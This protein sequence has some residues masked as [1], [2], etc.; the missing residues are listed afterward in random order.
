MKAQNT[1]KT[2]GMK[3][4]ALI[5]G[6]RKWVGGLWNG[7]RWREVESRVVAA[8]R[9]KFLA[10]FF[11]FFLLANVAQ[12]S[13]VA[14]Q[15]FSKLNFAPIEEP[16]TSAPLQSIG[17]IAVLVED[18]LMNDSLSY[19]GLK[20]HQLDS[21]KVISV[22]FPNA[23]TANSLAER[24]QRYALD[25]QR[26]RSLQKSHIIK[27]PRDAD[28]AEIANTLENIYLQGEAALLNQA[29]G[30]D[31][32][33]AVGQGQ[34]AGQ[35]SKLVGVVVIGD[36][37]LPVINKGGYRFVSMYPYTDFS[38][39]LYI[40]DPGKK[41]FVR[42]SD[43]ETG[44]V[45]VWHGV[46]KPPVSGDTGN[47]LLA[48]YFDKNHL[49]H[50]KSIDCFEPAQEFKN[51]SKKVLFADLFHEWESMNKDGY[52]NYVRYLQNMEDFAYSRF[53]KYLAGKLNGQFEDSLKE[54][55]GIDNDGDGLIDE[56]PING[57]DD[58]GDG[59]D[60]SPLIGM[61]NGID[62]N[63]NGEVD[64]L[65][66]G[67]WGICPDANNDDIV[68]PITVS[69]KLRDCRTADWANQQAVRGSNYFSVK[70]GSLYKIS[71]EIDNDGNG[72]IDE[73]IDEDNGDALKG[74]DNDFDGLIDEDTTQDND[75]DGDGA[76][77]EDGPGDMNDDNCPGV[78]GQDEDGDSRD[79]DGD[80]YPNGYEIEKGSFINGLYI[81]TNPK[82]YTSFPL[83]MA[84]V[85]PL[86]MI[87]KPSGNPW[88]DEGSPA[89]DDEDGLV[90]EDG[91][92]DND[93]DGDGMVDEDSDGGGTT[94]SL[95]SLPDAFSRDLIEKFAA[96]YDSLFDKFKA[97]INDWIGYTGRY[98]SSYT[99][100][101]VAKSDV[102]TIPGLITIKDKVTEKYLRLAAD[103][104]EQ[105]ID[106]LV[107]QKLVAPVAMLQG[108]K[109]QLRV[110]F[111]DPNT[112]HVF[113]PILE[114][115]N[116]ANH[117]YSY[118]DPLNIPHTI[119]FLY[120]N[121]K[122]ATEIKST[123]ECS[124]YRGSQG[125]PG[126]NSALVIAS[127]LYNGLAD[128]TE[129]KAYAGCIGKN[130][131]LPE[132][133]FI[134]AA[135]KPV[136]DILGTKLIDAMTPVSESELDYRACFD[137]K[138][139]KAYE[140]YTQSVSTF[141]SAASQYGGSAEAINEAVASGQL[142]LPGSPYVTADNLVLVDSDIFPLNKVNP[143]VPLVDPSEQHFRLTLTLADFLK[144]FGGSDGVDNNGDGVI[145][146]VAE[147]GSSFA[148]GN[149]DF[150]QIG[151]KILQGK[152]ITNDFVPDSRNF[153]FNKTTIPTLPAEVGDVYILVE[154][155]PAKAV[156]SGGGD[157]LV[158]SFDMHKEPTQETIDAQTAPGV[159]A[160]SLPIDNPR[161]VT[162]QDKAGNFQRLDY[163]KLFAYNSE[164][165]LA[166]IL[167]NFEKKLQQIADD[168]N[169][170]ADFAGT[171]TS[172]LG[173]EDVYSDPVAKERLYKIDRNKLDD[174]YVWKG[175][176][177]DDKHDYVISKYLN[178]Y[179]E[180][181]FGGETE[182]GYEFMY[183]VAEG[184]S[185]QML[186]GFNA[187]FNLVDE[188]SERKAIDSQLD[189]PTTEP[190]GGSGGG[191]G[192]GSDDGVN[193]LKWFDAIVDWLAE[194]T[195]VKDSTQAG[196]VCLFADALGDIAE[197]AADSETPAGSS[198]VMLDFSEG[199]TEAKNTAQ[200]SVASDKNVMQAGSSDIATITVTGLNDQGQVQ[201]KDS[202]TKVQL[203][204]DP[205]QDAPAELYS[206]NPSVLINGKATFK[207]ITT[208]VVGNFSVYAIDPDRPQV[209]SNSVSISATNKKIRLVTYRKVA[210]SEYQQGDLIGFIIKDYD[211]KIITFVNAE[212]G[213]IDLKDDRFELQALPSGAGKPVRLT[214]AFKNGGEIVASVYF[215]VDAAKA[216]TVDDAAVNYFSGDYSG[217]HVK[218]TDT[219]DNY[220]IKSVAYDSVYNANGAY[221]YSDDDKVGIVDTS[222]NLFLTKDYSLGLNA[223]VGTEGPVVFDVLDS[224]KKIIAELFVAADFPKIEIIREEGDFADFNL[225]YHVARNAFAVAFSMI[226]DRASLSA[227]AATESIG[228]NGL[229]DS[230]SD[231][232][233]DF[234]EII[235]GL[236]YHKADS[237]GDGFNDYDELLDN[238]DPLKAGAVLFS[239]L[240]NVS[241]GFSQIINLF[242]RGV[243]RR[244]DDGTFRP[245]QLL[246]RDEF[247]ELNFGAICVQCTNFSDNVKTAIDTEYSKDPFPD[248]NIR[249][250]LLYCVKDAKN[251]TIVSG[252]QG[253]STFGFFLPDQSIS[254]AEAVKV[255]L[256]T[257]QLEFG[258]ITVNDATTPG[259]PWYYNYVVEGQKQALFPAGTFVELDGDS[260]AFVSWFDTQFASNGIFIKWLEGS[261]TRREF[262]MMVSNFSD[263]YNC[264]LK[265]SDGD[266]IPDNFEIYVYGTS[267]TSD[268]TD[269]GGVKDM[270]ELL[271]NTNP[272]DPKDDKRVL[273]PD[274]DDDNDGMPNG[275]EMTYGF[276]PY[277]P[278]DANDDPDGD[279]LKNLK[280][281]QI[282]TD[283]LDPDTDDGG[284][285]DGDEV[286]REID[287]LN[288]NDD[289]FFGGAEGGFI[290]GDTV[291]ENYSYAL[292]TPEPGQ[293]AFD[294]EYINEMP[295]DGQSS[296]YLRA[297]VVDENGDA[298]ETVDGSLAFGAVE[299]DGFATV[300]FDSM[301]ITE[302]VAENV[303]TSKLKAGD[304]LAT[305]SFGDEYPSEVFDVHVIPLE[306]ANIEL[307]VDSKVIKSGGESFA[308]V[309]AEL[310]D[311]NLNLINNDIQQLTFKISGGRAD[312]TLDE[313]P[314]MDGV[315]ISSLDGKFDLK[316]YSVEQSGN[317][318]VT[319]EYYSEPDILDEIESEIAEE[320]AVAGDET[321]DPQ[322]TAVKP[323]ITESVSVVTRDDLNLRLSAQYSALPSDFTSTS[324]LKLSVTDFV[325]NVIEDF[326]GVARFSVSNGDLGSVSVMEAPIINGGGVA[327]FTSGRI[328]GEASV[329]AA[330]E[331]FDSAK[332]VIAIEPKETK[333]IQVESNRDYIDANGGI[334]TTI[335]AKLFDADGNFAGND[336]TTILRF[337]LSE[338]SKKFAQI[339]GGP[340]GYIDIQAQNGI[341]QMDVTGISLS[342]N[343][344]IKVSAPG[345]N[346][347]YTE[348]KV[349][350]SFDG[351]NFRGINPRVLYSSLLGADFGNIFHED[352]LAGWLIFS[353]KTQ[354]ATS[355]ISP[356]TPK[357]RLVEVSPYGK[358][359][360]MDEE[361]IGFKYVDNRV[362]VTDFQTR[363]DLGEVVVVMN[364][365]STAVVIES[366]A[367]PSNFVGSVVVQLNETASETGG[368]STLDTA[369]GVN[370]LEND[371]LIA[372]VM[373]SGNIKVFG[374]GYS[375]SP[376]IDS[377]LDYSVMDVMS[378]NQSVASVILVP[379]SPGNVVLL[380][381][382]SPEVTSA[383]YSPGIYLRK[384]NDISTIGSDITF[385]GY[386]SAGAKGI[387]LTDLE[388]D[389]P[390]SQIPGQSFASLEKATEVS[391][392]GFEGD[393][394]HALLFAA[395]NTV[396]ESN[397]PYASEIGIVIGDP[398]IRM[399]NSA[400]IL[401][402]GFSNDIGS[403]IFMGSQAVADFTVI[404]YN[405]DGF[406]DLFVAY[407]DGQVRLLQ[408][409]NG[410]PRFEDRGE[411][412]RF[413]GGILSMSTADF[414][415]DGQ[416]DI[417]IA[418]K[419][420][421]MNG[422]IC[423]DV[424]ENHGGNFRRNNLN[425]QSFTKN[426][427]IYS[428][429]T[430]DMNNDGYSDIITSDDS[431]NIRLFYNYK[432]RI[433]QY[434][435]FIGNLGL[436]VDESDN[437]KTE[438]M[439]AYDGS[440]VKSDPNDSNFTTIN[441]KDFVYLDLD[442]KLG[443]QSEKKVKDMTEPFNSIGLGDRIEY[444]IVL[445]NSSA[446][447]LTNVLV[448]DAIPMTVGFD[449]TTLSCADCENAIGIE[450]SGVSLRPYVFGPISIPANGS[451]T[452]KYAATVKQTVK[453]NFYTGI[454]LDNYP[455]DPFPDIAA[456]PEGNSTG[457]MTYFY[458]TS[459]QTDPND[460]SR[461]TVD[462]TMMV[463]NP[464][465]VPPGT[466]GT[467]DLDGYISDMKTDANNNGV[468]DFLENQQK[469]M[470]VDNKQ[471]NESSGNSLENLADN[472]ESTIN[473]FTCSGGCLPLPI[474]YALFAPGL[475]NALGVPAGFDPGLPIFAAGIP[476]IWPFWPASPYQASQFRFY[477][478]PTLT[479]SLGYGFCFGPYL[480]G[481]CM[482]FASKGALMDALGVGA[483]ICDK[484][485][486]GI[487]SVL[488][489]VE[490][491]SMTVG[492]DDA[493]FI[494]DGT[495][496]QPAAGASGGRSG[497]GGFRSSTTLGNYNFV[498][499]V[500]TNFRIPGFPSVI[501]NW[502]DRQTEE[503]INKL[504]D[505]PDL[506]VFLPNPLSIVGAVV[507][508]DG[509]PDPSPSLS[510]IAN[511]FNKQ[512]N[513]LT[514]NPKS[515]LEFL[516]SMPLLQITTKD[517]LFKIPAV[518][519][520]E[521][522]RLTHDWNQW[523]EDLRNEVNRVIGLWCDSSNHYDENW[524]FVE[525]DPNYN[526][527]YATICEKLV[528]DSKKLQKS[529]EKNIEVLEKY[530]ELP[531]KILAW[532]Q[533]TYKYLNQLICYFDA[534]VKLMGGWIST[535]QKRI[536]AW[537][538]E[539]TKVIQSIKDFKFILDIM[540]EYASCDKCSTS[541]FSLFELLLRLFVVIPDPPIIPFPKWPDIYFDL[542]NIQAGISVVWPDLRFRPEP[543]IFPKLPRIYLPDVPSLTVILPELPILPDPPDLPDLPDLPPLSLPSLPNIPPPPTLPK[544]VP[545]SVK[546]TINTLKQIFRILCLLRNGLIWVPETALKAQ[547]EQM[548]E[549]G[550]QF[551]LPID[552][553]LNVQYPPIELDLG[554]P[555]KIEVTGYLNMQ[556][557]FSSIYDAVKKFSDKANKISTNLVKE[558]NLL[559]KKASD[560]AQAAADKANEKLE[561]PLPEED[562]TVDLSYNGSF[563]PD[564]ISPQLA[565][566]MTQFEGAVASMEK[567]AIEYQKVVDSI[568]DYHL[569]AEQTFIDPSDPMLNRPIEEIENS[570][571]NEEF[572]EMAIQKQL[573]ATRNSLIDY[574]K[575]QDL[576]MKKLG[577]SD[578]LEYMGRVLAEAPTL[579]ELLDK[580]KIS[581][582]V[583]TGKAF[584][585]T[586]I[587]DGTAD[588]SK[589][590]DDESFESTA[591]FIRK[592]FVSSSELFADYGIPDIT[593]T[594][595]MDSLVP[596]PK[597]IFVFNKTTQSNERIVNYTA[598][599]GQPSKLIYMDVD[600]DGDSDLIYSLGGN[601][602]LK[603]NYKKSP[604]PS[605]VFI[606]DPA[607]VH[608]LGNI[609]P[610]G[611]AVNNLRST[612]NNNRL[613]ELS[614]K[615]VTGVG[616]SGGNA[617]GYEILLAGAPDAFEQNL[618]IS[619]TKYALVSGGDSEYIEQESS[620]LPVYVPG[621]TALSVNGNTK[622][623][624][625]K[626]ELVVSG[627]NE[628]KAYSGLIIHTFEDSEIV[629][630]GNDQSNT[631]SILR[632]RMFTIPEEF[633][634][635][636]SVKLN[637]GSVEIVN[638]LIK[639]EQKL[640]VGMMIEYDDQIISSD[641]ETAAIGIKDESV[642][643]TA[644]RQTLNLQKIA[645]VDSPTVKLPLTN[646]FYY[647]GIRYFA[648]NG[649]YGVLSNPVL[650]SPSVCADKQPPMPNAGPLDRD[651][652][653]FKKLTI[654]AGKSQDSNGSISAY[655]MD[656]DLNYDTDKD[657]DTQND[658]DLFSDLDATIDS[659]GDG[660][661]S[662]DADNWVFEL[663][664][665]ENLDK[666]LVR[667]NVID[668]SNN[669][670]GQI[671]N[672]NVFVPT[673]TIDQSTSYEG[674]IRGSVDPGESEIPVSIIRERDGIVQKINT[675]SANTDGKYLSDAD[676]KITVDDL[677]LEDSLVIKNEDGE[678][679][680]EINPQ[681]GQI[682]LYDE[683]NYIL[684]VLPAE[685]PLL[686]TRVVLKKMTGQVLL[687]LFLVPD[688]NTD[689]TIDPTEFVYDADSV[690]NFVGAHIKDIDPFD[691]L[692]MRLIP[693]NDPNYP[694]AT[695][696]I[697]SSTMVRAA[698]MDSGGNFYIFDPDLNLSLR[699]GA[700]LNDPLII[701]ISD[702]DSPVGE[703]YIAVHSKKGVSFVSPDKF[704]LFIEGA[705]DKG[706][707]YDSDNDGM[708]DIW[709][710][711]YGL[712]PNDPSDARLDIDNDGLTNLEEY[713]ALS[714]PRIA[715]TDGDGYLDGE[716][717]RFGQ[718][719][720]K[721]AFSPF[722]DVTVDHPFFRSILNLNQRNILKGIPRGDSL[723]FGPDES[724]PRA[725]F[726]KIML[727]I[728][729]IIPR[730][731]AFKGPS[732]FSDMPYV[733]GSL[734]WFYAI[735]KE[736]NLQNFVTGY[737]GESDPVTGK[738]PFRAERGISK[739]ETIK[740]ILEALETR[741]VID[742]GNVPVMEP[743][744][745]PYISIARDLTPYLLKPE[746]VRQTFIVTDEESQNPDKEIT[747]AEFIAM[748]DRVL[749]IF[750]CS[751]LD[752]DGDGIPG[753]FERLYGLN[754]F[755]PTDADD[756][757][758]GDGLTNLEEYRHGTDPRNPDTDQGGVKDGEEVKK[759]TNPRNNPQDDP[760][761]TDGDGLTDKAETQVFKTDPYDPDTDKGGVS[762]GDEVLKYNT[763]PLNP[764]DDGDSDGDG[765]SDYEEINTYGTD[766]FD[767]DT[768]DG[769]VDDGKEVFRGTDPLFGDD[770]LIDPRSDLEEG[771]YV[772]IEE[773]VQCPCPITIEHTADLI[774]GDI[775]YG[776]ISDTQDKVIFT[777]SN[778]V[779]ITR[780]T[781]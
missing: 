751:T 484:I 343:A 241:K 204:I 16:K 627:I 106:E 252:Y 604:S 718:D 491:V 665:Y 574:N 219:N 742:M 199:L 529:I 107:Q 229:I 435:Q 315:Q 769:G 401:N 628:G 362:V 9:R 571:R 668:E 213:A 396:G 208:G 640:I 393:N 207:I 594:P 36:V 268:D 512:T 281:Y 257:G 398:T 154:P 595:G 243:V 780:N 167:S 425:L 265:D 307:S 613:S 212:T 180:A 141:L 736:A 78:C 739:A 656:L 591:E 334:A 172:M 504:T 689:T 634:Q 26:V 15:N 683:T 82:S 674:V 516:N 31:L 161:Y 228:T 71:D 488:S 458:S 28:P 247:V 374:S 684:E 710:L 570:I 641:G 153:K 345:L 122:P 65:D 108:S 244:Y 495:G 536:E 462:Y 76:V 440:A 391:G 308:T 561:S 194:I 709:E 135:V 685:L 325:G 341:A 68:D 327:V 399:D 248:T 744:Y 205:A 33:G 37:P 359:S 347:A 140:A 533:I 5:A 109:L 569:V 759:G 434:G 768:D 34:V 17:V 282:G 98:R 660:N 409:R 499:D 361:R 708:P 524:N 383:S 254:R 156:L 296:L 305:A 542:S 565:L 626:R 21:G 284:V 397:I 157:M 159:A 48:E 404:D 530:K 144:V 431:G 774:S 133:C 417:L 608:E 646:G 60:G 375:V 716:E 707:L 94:V 42:N 483:D 657:G 781:K 66:E 58:D 18:S 173:N 54:G 427:R 2:E 196:P 269:Q 89:D 471:E 203:V 532:R 297:T 356:P 659:N 636:V 395:G 323:D 403:E 717:L 272:L 456:T 49:F 114:F 134:D 737:L 688:I 644:G 535:Q 687:T 618:D 762:D 260:G 130:A 379:L 424:Y 274:A 188:D 445:R 616:S 56:D 560:A 211:D 164:Q 703:F 280:E 290:V 51:F 105:R 339:L 549:R 525:N 663:G 728:F 551:L 306:P 238:F 415:R 767:P 150:K 139:K 745:M 475:I 387:A 406:D 320:G 700:T 349:S 729:C 666:R 351:K 163:P 121:G 770:D 88:I 7:R 443:I 318:T 357:A 118:T 350:H 481:T 178:P 319:A 580:N 466:A 518:T 419:D 206:Q 309:H 46:I 103:S 230:D 77:D 316:V 44:Q 8:R 271:D 165:E 176:N 169:V 704:K 539:I 694:G 696:I 779:T 249:P 582:D 722:A 62:D 454:N 697:D 145:D 673:L 564:L 602:Y 181:Y 487:N 678:I 753:Y 97:N 317:I 43:V 732:P 344:L 590:N 543:I 469:Q 592:Q 550:L 449:K 41:E 216:V 354:S 556:M 654:D 430:A 527:P 170:M 218:D 620:I 672:I 611:P 741:G 85:I 623:F 314:E 632:N 552:L 61:G 291:F 596:V 540:F 433:E 39:K 463:T 653:I 67:F 79:D 266:G 12:P 719:P 110:Q 486:D 455:A 468:P 171:L 559:M 511:K 119:P 338:Q 372:T 472:L 195:R 423:V 522:Q 528:V 143:L 25:I 47:K 333:Q 232:L 263:K 283:P 615:A 476:N 584:A 706:P 120:I 583:S 410:Y 264:M 477:L 692:E 381:V 86:P 192:G 234:E 191:G 329:T 322:T 250:D 521:V 289:A 14:A 364:P 285:S 485:T 301:G 609:V 340:L 534:V 502:L 53:S 182:N 453:V 132:L 649:E 384:L 407:S 662:N 757:P 517:V 217:V 287:P 123:N 236:D 189:V 73:G 113:G 382:G 421:C 392:V 655:W 490:G 147:A 601:I 137:M 95:E 321:E 631:L 756:D 90:D 75:A 497:S 538:T 614:W 679:I 311:V 441:Q 652:P 727:D 519:S 482:A 496:N 566:L 537:I 617:L 405:S 548:T 87:P 639:I 418:S 429:R 126:S 278:A 300:K 778:E 388:R 102:S 177:I 622:L 763:D 324:E 642:V 328:S 184:K 547:I 116:F 600:N 326:V 420:N 699:D 526:S 136:F 23:L 638:S 645:N 160:N 412:L 414:D 373:D 313:R 500:Q 669:L 231:G 63:G 747:R 365:E 115:I 579:G 651:V 303:L 210:Q 588:Q 13:I 711:T 624:G 772:I 275:Y 84:G 437:L 664:P 498:L 386:S 426:N 112:N 637:Y 581:E 648:Q 253:G 197:E 439:V 567:D 20:N 22:D 578:D 509:Q 776:I 515:W 226:R 193:I 152:D 336:S 59:E 563:D 568:Q 598:E 127:H 142:A 702:I 576:I 214:V 70:Q 45:E 91:T 245:D 510:S 459:L 294:I 277:D 310:K 589:M 508:Q 438:V 377:D 100:G 750:D 523:K 557:D 352:Y 299:G 80:G 292:V 733:A 239:D 175:L 202:F 11:L 748:A 489:G 661:P 465:Q 304:Y 671:I 251:K 721:K 752:E 606:G 755:D 607:A 461:T 726:A 473:K 237:D 761:D 754:P 605:N 72:L 353:G 360:L 677:T 346:G 470:V 775:I 149:D 24:V 104:I 155:D 758:D 720:L 621:M 259:K 35:T 342:G 411:I 261:I 520:K 658:R 295:A 633:G 738:T 514:W 262:A 50:C 400:T 494:A 125:V 777:K 223:N 394:K 55:D 555:S 366:D 128:P 541:R 255:I 629:I 371:Q 695:E 643:G 146:E 363:K 376:N 162:F 444:T 64:E 771:I 635:D 681:T 174:I 389:L 764:K 4:G 337:A 544:L 457:K 81:P 233:N 492:T 682:V 480:T 715:D 507:P 586:V 38:E 712:N 390:A 355:L 179:E 276:N 124:L 474:N 428:I 691:E 546:V 730:Q 335:T 358:T 513:K 235:L 186:Y 348:L 227:H 298:D 256:K 57:V 330:V 432:G 138:E 40:F 558:M 222:G 279:G 183:L 29:N 554:I 408:N 760:I 240:T 151:S 129:E 701:E 368:L 93:N 447:T 436:H 531:R 201:T 1:H 370:I 723:L 460:G 647:A 246:R 215:V 680:G 451:R 331:G 131:D 724:I 603:E 575:H 416:E 587:P 3:F 467:I 766:P 117:P 273:D 478:S 258:E 10:S 190:G 286:V 6:A 92:A 168:S 577:T 99:E 585:S 493:A 675:D 597:G 442:V 450:D 242:K 293:G 19:D 746:L 32:I 422:E 402:S 765:L 610:A 740:V 187:D 224:R 693:S 725:E 612:Y 452:I 731:E 380:P 312:E 378:G 553:G 96:S 503:I 562:T 572:P 209:N 413:D 464:E 367:D 505:F 650:L 302:G 220:S 111:A 221:L 630:E 573:V 773:C 83:M 690:K 501:T 200:F 670:S 158:S 713:L 619:F 446:Q 734:P 148:I 185:D 69:Q 27:I 225:A 749:T 166:L 599:L 625:S 743:Y 369:T 735:V 30:A 698:L 676:G 74:I 198:P 288:G 448:S 686:P 714:N 332:T 705:N 267:P 101:G 593:K 667:V 545:I 385:A 479:M 270:Q 52:G 506:Y